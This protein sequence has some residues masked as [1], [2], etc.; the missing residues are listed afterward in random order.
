MVYDYGDLEIDVALRDVEVL[1]R[2]TGC[3]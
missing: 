3:E 1:T 2:P